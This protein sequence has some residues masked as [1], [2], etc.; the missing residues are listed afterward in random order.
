MDI[1]K[2]KTDSLFEERESFSRLVAVGDWIFMSNTAGANPETKKMPDDA[3][4]QAEQAFANV[5]RALKTAGATLAD[6]VRARITVPIEADVGDVM[7]IVGAKFKGI[8]PTM[9]VTCSPLAGFNLRFEI[10]ITAYRGAGSQEQTR[11]R[12]G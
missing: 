8:D 2:L 5:E 12:I 6:V 10:E 9:T 11:G 4:G 1:L 3:I 7:P